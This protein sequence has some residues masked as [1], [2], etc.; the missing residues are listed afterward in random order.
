MRPRRLAVT[1]ARHRRGRRGGL[2]RAASR[3][4]ARRSTRAS[5][6]TRARPPRSTPPTGRGWASSRATTLRTPIT[7]RRH[8]AGRPP[9]DGRDRGPPLLQARGRRLR[10][11]RARRG[12]ERSSGDDV[13]GGSTLTM[14]LVRNLYTGERA[15]SGVAGYKRKIREAKLA[16]ELE[17]RHP[18]HQGKIWILNKYLNTVPYGTVGGQTAVGIQAA[19]RMFFDKPAGKLTLRQA[20]LLAGPA[21]GALAYNPFLDPQRAKQRRNEVLQQDGRPGLHQPGDRRRPRAPRRSASSRTATTPSA[22]RATSSTTS[23]QQADRAVRRGRASARAGCRSTRRS[24]SAP[25]G[26]ARER[27]RAGSPSPATA[28]RRS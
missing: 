5:R 25:A 10:G 22:A 26:G 9:G 20:A 7:E 14:Q 19:S 28:P 8:P 23:S 6:S 18:G 17:N 4:R 2:G 24:T 1:V 11:H 16:E 21:A 3:R 12:Q 27:S 15:R 13:Q